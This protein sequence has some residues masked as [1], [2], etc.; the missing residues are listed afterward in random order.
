[1]QIINSISE[2]TAKQKLNVAELTAIL[3]DENA[4]IDQKNAALKALK[5]VADGY[6]DGLTLENAATAEGTRLIDRYIKSIDQLAE[7]KA[8]VDVKS[9]L[10]TDKILSE[11]KVLALSLEKKANKNEGIAGSRGKGDDGKIFGIGDRNK[12]EIESEMDDEKVQTKSFDLQLQAIDKRKQ[13]KIK[14]LQN[15]IAKQNQSLKNIKKDSK[16]FKELTQDIKNNTDSL[17]ILIGLPSKSSGTATDDG[18]VAVAGGSG[19]DAKKTKEKNPNTDYRTIR[20]MELEEISK[21]NE[22]KLKLERQYED[23]RIANMVDGYDKEVALENKRYQ[24]QIEELNNK[25]APEAEM[26][27]VEN[28]IIKA[29]KDGNETMVNYLIG[30]KEGWAKKNEAIDKKVFE[31]EAQFFTAHNFKLGTIQE[32]A[33]KD[34]L[35]KQHDQFE[36]EKTQRETAFYTELNALDLSEAERKKRIEGF[37]KAEIEIQK[38]YLLS[39]VAEMRKMLEGKTIDGIGFNLLSAKDKKK[40]ENDIA[41]VL[42]AVAKIDNPKEGKVKSEFSAFQ[43]TDI[44]GFSADQ[45]EKTF[46]NLDTTE[47]KMQAIGMALGAMTNMLGKY[48]EFVS[49]TENAALKKDEQAANKKK[50]NL[51]KQLDAGYINQVQYKR[52]VENIDKDLDRKKAEL[53]YN[54]AKRQ[55][56]LAV[57]GI[58]TSTAQAIIGI[59][60]QFPKVDFGVTAGIMSGVVGAL[61]ALQLATVMATPLPAKGFEDGLYPDYVKREQDGKIFKARNGGITK[62]G[63]VTSPTYFLAG[64]GNKPEMIIDNKAWRQLSPDLKDSLVRQLRGV[65]GFEKGYYQNEV[66]F[67]GAS[68]SIA[69]T[70]ETAMP[71]TNN[72]DD[73]MKMF[74]AVMA[75]NTAVLRDLRD[76]PIEA[77]VTNKNLK[78]MKYLK[79]GIKDFDTLK[80]KNTL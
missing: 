40:L 16:Q 56:A 31:L 69:S 37:N 74:M 22:A 24:R 20:L 9:K 21:Q 17:N 47:A 59:W 26:M 49:A 60:A 30:V 79:D 53:E 78:S 62:S 73:M 54:Q 7:A 15:S 33:G 65:K 72:N 77:L 4:T 19:K 63:M 51:K 18:T 12:V 23:E 50:T 25:K 52:G 10:I 67:S 6:L 80:S 76:N 66:L 75:E 8:I 35:E 68:K 64:E 44:L 57:I 46:T 3:K 36:L 14:S 28:D 1:L 70:V 61:G 29:R 41:V 39:K 55:K 32:K 11:N 48:N 34:R 5:K 58:I 45:W 71:S 2:Q 42:N 43:N 27:K 38:T 13:S